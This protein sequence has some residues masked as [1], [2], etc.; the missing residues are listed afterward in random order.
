VVLW[1]SFVVA[2]SAPAPVDPGEAAFDNPAAVLDDEGSLVSDGYARRRCVPRWARTDAGVVLV[3]FA[4]IRYK[5]MDRPSCGWNGFDTNP[6][7]RRPFACHDT[8]PHQLPTRDDYTLKTQFDQALRSAGVRSR[9]SPAPAT[10]P[11]RH[12]DPSI[13]TQG[14]RRARICLRPQHPCP[15]ITNLG[16]RIQHYRLNLCNGIQIQVST[17]VAVMQHSQPGSEA[18]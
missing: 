8:T 12:C 2:D 11:R 16:E 13:I 14:L 1:E 4:A 3:G 7:T 6:C 5:D 15:P 10:R 17:L 9:H 18:T